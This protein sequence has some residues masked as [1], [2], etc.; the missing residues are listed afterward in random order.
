M[1]VSI[2]EKVKRQHFIFYLAAKVFCENFKSDIREA[3][4]IQIVFTRILFISTTYIDTLLS[5]TS[6]NIVLIMENNF[7]LLL[8]F[9]NICGKPKSSYGQKCRNGIRAFGQRKKR[10]NYCRDK[11]GAPFKQVMTIL[12]VKLSYL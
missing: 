2:Q 3:I 12:S 8:K 10:V 1:S 9:R 7:L 4:F 11:N 6:F 5:I